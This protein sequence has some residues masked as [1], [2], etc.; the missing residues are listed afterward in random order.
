MPAS[1]M[2]GIVF[3][4]KNV[5]QRWYSFNEL[6]KTS[7]SCA[8]GVILLTKTIL[9]VAWLY[10]YN[11]DGA[12]IGYPIYLQKY[13]IQFWS[14]TPVFIALVS[15]LELIHRFLVCF[16]ERQ[17]NMMTLKRWAVDVTNI[18]SFLSLAWSASQYVWIKSE[19]CC[20]WLI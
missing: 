4:V 12:P 15:A 16:L 5:C 11:L 10:S 18:L 13:I 2:F 1:F 14:T 19:Y 7:R 8:W 3:T 9:M 17:S 20:V 6:M